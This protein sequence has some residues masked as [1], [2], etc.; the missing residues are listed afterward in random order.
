MPYTTASV[1]KKAAVAPRIEIPPTANIIESG[2]GFSQHI[3]IV[4]KTTVRIRY[5]SAIICWAVTVPLE[6]TKRPTTELL[7]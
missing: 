5:P 7:A 2:K 1:I 4:K 3:K 6:T